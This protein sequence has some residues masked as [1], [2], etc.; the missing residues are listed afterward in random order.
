MPNFI[1]EIINIPIIPV[2]LLP[3]TGLLCLTFYNRTASMHARLRAL[4]KELRDLHI[5]NRADLSAMEKE[6]AHALYQEVERLHTRSRLIVFSLICCLLSIFL[7]CICA[8]F[9][10][11]SLFEPRTLEIAL[12]FWF[13]GPILICLG[14]IAGIWEL[15]RS[16]A[17]IETETRLI[18]KWFRL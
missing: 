14:I 3:V 5:K 13:C 17:S 11:F 1:S 7:F 10:V 8:L 12:V 9:V 18:S 15:I 2:L 4:Q 6:L 16:F